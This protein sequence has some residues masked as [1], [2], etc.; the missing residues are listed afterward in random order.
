M[1]LKYFIVRY[2]IQTDLKKKSD[3]YSVTEM[4]GEYYLPENH[5]HIHL[6]LE[7]WRNVLCLIH[8]I[9]VCF[10]LMQMNSENIKLMFMLLSC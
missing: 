7:D 8:R 10:F 6:I 4:D 1:L 9:P 3:G 2:L 5:A